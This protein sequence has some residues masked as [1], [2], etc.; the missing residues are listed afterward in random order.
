[1]KNAPVDD[2]IIANNSSD[3][4]DGFAA[5]S[6]NRD[7]KAPIFDKSIVNK[8]PVTLSVFLGN[9]KMTVS[10]LMDLK[11]GSTVSLDASLNHRA[12][13]QLNGNVV[14]YGEIVAV[15]DKFGIR[16]TEMGD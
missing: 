5:P 11:D 9:A 7:A 4:E 10:E 1:M 6:E 16:I 14:G 15:G 8:V 12:E 13:L 2:L 3:S